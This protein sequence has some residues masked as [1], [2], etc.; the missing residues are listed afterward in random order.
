MVPVLDSSLSSPSD[1][2]AAELFRACRPGVELRSLVYLGAGDFCRAYLRN[3]HEVV[4]VPRHAEARRA[5]IR[6]ACVLPRLAPLL[7]A[8]VPG[9][10][11]YVDGAGESLIS[12]HERL[13]GAEL[14]L[15]LWRQ[16]P[17]PER[18][19]SAHRL[20]EFLESLHR[21]DAGVSRDCGVPVVDHG[22]R[23]SQLL[24]V[25]R[26]DGGA[27]LPQPERQALGEW[28]SR[29]AVGGPDWDYAPVTLHADVSPEHVLVSAV[30]ATI[31][32]VIDWGDVCIGDPAR[33]FIYLYEDWGPEFLG[34]VL[35]GYSLESSNRIL[36]RIHM[37]YVIDQLAWT[38]DA[39]RDRRVDDVEHGVEALRSA[40]ADLESSAP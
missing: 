26:G 13:T 28:L 34:F 35:D 30:S 39:G 21:I 15:E 18:A 27:V 12:I 6:E 2:Q 24:D 4:R 19:L 29:Y 31:T 20:G 5:L 1:R 9:T 16:L 17:D 8:P 40:L 33:D 38:L 32:G 36:P 23:A 14:T 3:G 10:E 22:A 37:H 7:S 25:V 11:V